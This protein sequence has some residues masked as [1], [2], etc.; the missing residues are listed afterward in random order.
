MHAVPDDAVPD[1]VPRGA[2][3]LPWA[4]PAAGSGV[5]GGG[6][7]EGLLLLGQD[8]DI[9]GDL[10]DEKQ[11]FSG[12]LACL[13]VW[14]RA[15]TDPEIAEQAD[16]SKE[17]R[18]GKGDIVSWI[19]KAQWTVSQVPI[20]A[21]AN[22]CSAQ[23]FYVFLPTKMSHEE[24]VR[25]C[26]SFGGELPGDLDWNK[27]TVVSYEDIKQ[28]CLDQLGVEDNP[29]MVPEFAD[30]TFKFWTDFKIKGLQTS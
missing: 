14:S 5:G 19:D 17:D 28:A 24:S 9:Y 18:A 8:P 25:Q 3:T 6:P 1:R 10:F 27:Q 13:G 29:C 20:H 22:F 23:H 2:D 4:A 21:Q 30:K 16:C 11:A 26:G 12:S 15:L 7:E